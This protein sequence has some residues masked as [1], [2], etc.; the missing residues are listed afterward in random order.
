VDLEGLLRQLVG[1]P[2]AFDEIDLA[3]MRYGELI[4]KGQLSPDELALLGRFLEAWAA[5]R[6]AFRR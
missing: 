5:I 4:K 6:E 3:V 2:E 1:D